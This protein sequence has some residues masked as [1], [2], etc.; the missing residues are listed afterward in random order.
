MKLTIKSQA[1]YQHRGFLFFKDSK[2]ISKYVISEVDS[3]V[4]LT[5][6]IYD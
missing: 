5:A 2:F 1:L 4:E 3:N 6:K